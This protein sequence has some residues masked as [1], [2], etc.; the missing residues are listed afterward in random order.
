MK[1]WVLDFVMLM[2][3]FF[4]KDIFFHQEYYIDSFLHKYVNMEANFYSWLILLG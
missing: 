1:L 2:T 4:M 3:A